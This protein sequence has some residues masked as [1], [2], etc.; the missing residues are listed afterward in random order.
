[1]FKMQSFNEG[2]HGK[3]WKSLILLLLLCVLVISCNNGNHIENSEAS[4]EIRSF[5]G[6]STLVL[7]SSNTP[8]DY[9]ISIIRSKDICLCHFERGDSINQYLA[10]HKLPVN[11]SKY[12]KDS[13]GVYSVKMDFPVLK[14]DTLGGSKETPDM[15][16]MDVNFDG[17]EEFVVEYE[18]Y[19]R[20]YYACFDLINGNNKSA[21]PGLLEPIQDEPYNNIVSFGSLEPSYTVFDYEKKEIY[22]YESMGCCSH[23]ETWAKYF[24]GNPDEFK[25]PRIKVIKRIDYDFYA[26][27]TTHLDTYMLKNDTLKLVKKEVK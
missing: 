27:G 5:F 24:L 12:E 25:E 8:D 16:F 10:I 23:Q 26:D 14:I 3:L 11:L 2:S 7:K 20:V 6:D 19:N 9:Q 13:I 18:G 1:M 17:E 4:E 21:S 15:F 22:I